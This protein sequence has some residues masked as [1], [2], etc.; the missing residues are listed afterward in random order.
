[1]PEIYVKDLSPTSRR[2]ATM[3]FRRY[4]TILAFALLANGNLAPAPARA[5]MEID[6]FSNDLD[7]KI[8]GCTALLERGNLTP[9]ERARLYADR[10]LALSMKG[11]YAEAIKDYDRSLA[12]QPNASIPLNNRAWA[13]FRWGRAADGVLDVE[14]SLNLDPTSGASYDTRA[15][16]RQSLSNPSG[17]FAD[18]RLA[19]KFGGERMIKMYQCGL[20]DHGL[21]R[22]PVDGIVN[23]ELD[24]A[25]ERC[26]TDRTCDPLPANE[27]CRTGTS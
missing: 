20:T 4:L 10:A 13:Y 1:M 22:G 6:C 26:S 9:D 14:K 8:R 18:Y 3:K 27:E 21:Y 19:M 25:L 17:A 15:H 23:P 12:I 7:A 11:W 24:A 16:I 5:D 2:S